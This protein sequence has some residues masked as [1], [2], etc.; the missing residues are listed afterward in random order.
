MFTKLT[1]PQRIQIGLVLAI[2][3][4]LVL[5]SNRL[6]QKHFSRIQ[7]TVNSVYQD[8][9][10]V[11]DFIYQLNNIFHQKELELL[12]QEEGPTKPLINEKVDELLVKFGT[13]EMTAEESQL[14]NELNKKYE[15]LKDLETRFQEAPLES[16]NKYLGQLSNTL[17]GMQTTLDGLARIQLDESGQLTSISNRSF[18]MNILLSKLEV[19]F[20][21]IIGLAMFA[22]VFYPVSTLQTITEND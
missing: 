15:R 13:T 20:L 14:L 22:L 10:V 7:T 4:L 18:G 19:G 5:G 9:V 2:A 21:I 6:D 1:I 12:Q 8:R 11:Q 3:F 16:S 17:K